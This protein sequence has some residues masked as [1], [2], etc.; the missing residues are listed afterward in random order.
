MNECD[1]LTH[2]SAGL[3]VTTEYSEYEPHTHGHHR[4][5]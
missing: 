5:R 1:C 2:R 4:I 3:K